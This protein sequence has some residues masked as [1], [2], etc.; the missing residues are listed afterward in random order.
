[1]YDQERMTQQ[2]LFVKLFG[3]PT[4]GIIGMSFFQQFK[5]IA[6]GITIFGEFN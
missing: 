2:V 5:E 3:Y 1:L 6:R 4:T